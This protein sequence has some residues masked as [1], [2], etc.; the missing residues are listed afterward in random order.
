MDSPVA[1]AADIARSLADAADARG[2]S[3][4]QLAQMTGIPLATLH[5]R[6]AGGAARP[7]DLAEAL[8]IS[9]AIECPLSQL[10]ES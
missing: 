8:A 6:L 7:L 10:I 9:E 3:R 5:R 1:R 2:V 4:R